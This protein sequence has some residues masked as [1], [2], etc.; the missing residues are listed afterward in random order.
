MH[1]HISTPWPF[2][3]TNDEIQRPGS[4]GESEDHVHFPAISSFFAPCSPGAKP[5]FE[6]HGLV[7]RHRSVA[8]VVQEANTPW[9]AWPVLAP[10][11][12]PVWRM[13]RLGDGLSA[14]MADFPWCPM[15]VSHGRATCIAELSAEEGAE[16]S[17]GLVE[18]R[19]RGGI[20]PRNSQRITAAMV[21]ATATGIETAP[22]CRGSFGV[23]APYLPKGRRDPERAR[24]I[25]PRDPRSTR[26]V[27]EKQPPRRRSA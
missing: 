26:C 10:S 21:C 22:N 4:G 3:V 1:T 27:A 18:G 17:A 24:N 19:R 16:E 11:L 8:V 23:V 6:I 13:E 20:A 12:G 25:R 14:S 7:M 9:V 2:S 5:P 15:W